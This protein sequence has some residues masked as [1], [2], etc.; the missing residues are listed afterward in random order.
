[1]L[2]GVA[3]GPVQAAGELFAGLR[4]HTEPA[5][6]A[7][8]GLCTMSLYTCAGCLAHMPAKRCAAAP[9]AAQAR[10]QAAARSGGTPQM[11]RYSSCGCSWAWQL[12]GPGEASRV[13]GARKGRNAGGRSRQAEGDAHRCHGKPTSQH[14]LPHP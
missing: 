11:P 9:A 7:E 10:T 12:G 5:W 3:V 6:Q 8:P 1:M 14:R 13:W 2:G 4:S